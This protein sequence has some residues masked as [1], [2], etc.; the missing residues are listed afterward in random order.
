M[1]HVLQLASR[2]TQLEN[3]FDKELWVLY[4]SVPLKRTKNLGKCC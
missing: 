1:Y 3:N 2:M 4:N